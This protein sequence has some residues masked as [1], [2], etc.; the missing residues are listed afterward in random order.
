MWRRKLHA[1]WELPP[2]GA[3]RENAKEQPQE[4][5]DEE[6]YYLSSPQ[7]KEG[8][9]AFFTILCFLSDFQA[10]QPAQ[11]TPLLRGAPPE[12]AGGEGKRRTKKTEEDGAVGGDGGDEGG[13]GA[14]SAATVGEAG[15]GGAP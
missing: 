12:T 7:E 8:L 14:G 3:T 5:G 13:V 15:G 11:A 9:F 2:P 10:P 1:T 6:I 4:T